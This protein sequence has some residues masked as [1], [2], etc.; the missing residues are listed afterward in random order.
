MYRFF[1]NDD[2]GNIIKLSLE[3][4]HHYEK[5]LR[6]KES[7]EVE[8]CTDKGIYICTFHDK[9]DKNILLIKSRKLDNKNESDVNLILLQGILK[10][11]KMDQAI[12]SAVEVG[13]KEIYPLK[14]KRVVANISE[15]EDK[16]ISRWQ[17]VAEAA[18]KQSK[19]DYIPKINNSI[20]ITEIYEKFKDKK[21]IL[22]YENEENKR[23][24]NLNIDTRDIVIIIGPEGGFEESEIEFL[25]NEGVEI[26]SLGNR[27]LRAETA[28]VC[29]CFYILYNLER[30]V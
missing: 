3:N 17:K 25:K 5:V 30:G 10:G 20:S 12:K 24:K 16:K 6:I 18:A 11:D 13:V 21:I 2:C 7:E 8:V 28:T 15:K 4:S 22:A 23:F 14:T 1:E 29:A 27:I 26:I 19:R 9:V